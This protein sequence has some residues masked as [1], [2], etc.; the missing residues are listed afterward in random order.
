LHLRSFVFKISRNDVVHLPESDAA[1]ILPFLLEV[2]FSEFYPIL[3]EVFDES[4]S[5]LLLTEK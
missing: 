2:T 4:A 5:N 1:K 3:L